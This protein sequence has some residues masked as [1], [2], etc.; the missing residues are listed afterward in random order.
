MKKPLICWSREED[1][2]ISSFSI[3]DESFKSFQGLRKNKS[4]IKSCYKK[5]RNIVVISTK[6]YSYC[7]NGFVNQR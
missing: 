7:K 5:Q 3:K 1:F 2:H 4:I 6:D